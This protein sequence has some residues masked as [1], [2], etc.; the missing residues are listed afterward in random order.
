MSDHAPSTGPEALLAVRLLGPVEVLVAGVPVVVRHGRQE[1]LVAALALRP[2]E[3]V[4]A[5]RLAE[6]LWPGD[7]PQDPANA[8]QHL[9]AQVRRA[10]GPARSRLVTVPGGYRLDL[11][12]AATDLGSLA[13]AVTGARDALA[14]GRPA[15][16]LAVVEAALG[17][18]R[19]EPFPGV[20]D[21]LL[22]DAVARVVEQRTAAELMAADAALAA[23]DPA[24]LARAGERLARTCHEN[25]LHEPAWQRRI[26]VLARTGRLAEALAMF[27]ALRVRLA[28]EL[29]ADPGP[30]LRALHAELLGPPAVSTAAG[31]RP[32]LPALPGTRL[33]GR[34][35]DLAA[36]AGWLAEGVR[37]VTVVGASGVGKTRLALEAVHRSERPPLVVP[38]DALAEGGDVA[39][40]VA[41]TLRLREVATRELSDVL[42][43]ALPARSLLLL[44]NAEHLLGRVAELVQHL[45]A[46]RGDLAVLVTSQWPLGLPG[47]HLLRLAPLAPDDAAT[48]L[49]LDRA[50]HGRP[51]LHAPTDA[52]RRAAREIAEQ[53][54]GLPL[55]LELAASQTRQLTLAQL[56][57]A[58]GRSL[59]L[60]DRPTLRQR[61]RH[62]RLA[63][64]LD[65]SLD[66][67][68]APQLHLLTSCAVLP[69]AF[70]AD[71]AAA[72][73]GRS[74]ENCLPALLDLADRSVV[75]AVD[76]ATASPDVRFCLLRPLRMHVLRRA[77]QTGDADRARDHLLR[78]LV[79]LAEEC[80]A[81]IRGSDQARWLVRGD[82]TRADVDAALHHALRTGR[83]DEAARLVAA[84]GRYW[85]WRGRLRDADRWTADVLAAAEP[86]DVGSA[87]RLGAVLAW[88]AFVHAERG[89]IAEATRTAHRARDLA[90]T[91]DDVDGQLVALA[92]LTL[93]PDATGS[94]PAGQLIAEALR[95]AAD[96]DDG[97]GVAWCVNR[98]GHLRLLAGDLAGARVDAV[99]SADRFVALGDRRA[100]C[101]ARL[102]SALVHRATGDR[103]AAHVLA[104]D[105][106]VTS[107][108]AHDLRTT[109]NAARLLADT[110]DDATVRDHYRALSGDLHARRLATN[111]AVAVDGTHTAG[112]DDA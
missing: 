8:L 98:R 69:G 35:D 67:L 59:A 46:R 42:A 55:A 112:R 83:T 18:W 87:P 4:P 101:W 26:A 72:V 64:A 91:A 31:G 78:R 51:Q 52:D 75:H 96:R 1:L 2:G 53:L 11:P 48:H 34:D 94:A 41:A 62:R 79:R 106:L 19:G 77:E 68:E 16:A 30:Q 100:A 50:A 82:D 99:E 6:E 10:L 70:D 49:F 3:A 40:A 12:D 22:F 76:P 36:L 61:P 66:L 44:D 93:L 86:L 25:P 27:E 29:G 103:T 28:D 92:A 81:G 63:D 109:A 58:L 54:D 32:T 102:L 39:A 21:G 108:A 24:A 110:S 111:R 80:D 23:D 107:R 89:E 74:D 104:T 97:W 20:Q 88:R 84:L 9:V 85:D 45:L 71:L 47:E 43:E 7:Q 14:A 60:L 95:L 13:A 38:L 17:L 33:F 90:A 15:V 73:A 57:A 105:V 56:S 37:L 5:A 65:W